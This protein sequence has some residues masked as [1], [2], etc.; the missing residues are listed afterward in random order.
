MGEIIQWRTQSVSVCKS[1]LFS[2][3]RLLSDVSTLRR[4]VKIDFSFFVPILTL[5]QN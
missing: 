5:R 4:Y 1:H 3:A 2:N